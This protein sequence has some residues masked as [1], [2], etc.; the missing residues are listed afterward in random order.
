MLKQALASFTRR[1]GYTII[2]NWQLS[3][4]EAVNDL[5][6]RFESFE[7]DLVLDVG[8]NE[9]Q[10]RDLLR[11]RVGY[12]GRII[13]F[14]PVPELANKLAERA[15]IDSLWNVNNIAL[16]SVVGSADFNITAGS[17]FS[18]LL[19]PR[20]DDARMF[21]GQNRVIDRIS[22]EISTLDALLDSIISKH[23]PKGVF[24]KMD[25]QGFEIEVLK[26]AAQ[27]L[28]FIAAIQAEVSVHRIYDG[29]PDYKDVI[30]FLQLNGFAISGVLPANEG[31]FPRL[32]DFDCQFVRNDML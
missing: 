20:Q 8:A 28:R 12:S 24:L 22:V 7:I 1:L 25:T 18:S 2:P 6:R 30:E 23:Q 21:S 4:F 5:K 16:G 3:S 29:A 15:K 31:H 13:S 26:G 10:Y 27:A 9:G 11:E 19:S 17:Q 32:I 14:E